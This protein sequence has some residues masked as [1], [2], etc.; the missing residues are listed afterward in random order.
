METEDKVRSVAEDE[1]KVVFF[2]LYLRNYLYYSNE[3][4][5]VV[6]LGA[7]YLIQFCH[8]DLFSFGN[9]LDLWQS[10]CTERADGPSDFI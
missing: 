3:N 9:T 7:A 5:L 1:P 2:A 10:H 6:T 4:T 8:E